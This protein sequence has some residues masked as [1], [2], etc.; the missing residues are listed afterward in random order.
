[1]A[2]FISSILRRSWAQ[3]RGDGWSDATTRAF[4]QLLT[5]FSVEERG[6]SHV[7][8]LDNELLTRLARRL[9]KLLA[10]ALVR[11]GGRGKCGSTRHKWGG[12]ALNHFV[13]WSS[14]CSTRG[15]RRGRC[16]AQSSSRCDNRSILS[17][18][19]VAA[20]IAHYISNGWQRSVRILRQGRLNLLRRQALSLGATETE[21][22]T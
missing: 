15:K 20:H 12:A 21:S 19:R 7:H 10:S 5:T 4:H 11:S 8:L 18:F 22:G 1:M 9:E 16:H 14:D 3:R 6:L 17:R 2:R 13:M